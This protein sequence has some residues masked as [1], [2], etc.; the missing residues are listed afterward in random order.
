ML[1]DSVV[2]EDSETYGALIDM[3]PDLM[4][5]KMSSLIPR[6][7]KPPFEPSVPISI[8][9]EKEVKIEVSEEVPVMP[10]DLTKKISG[11]FPAMPIPGDVDLVIVPATSD[12][13]EKVR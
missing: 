10:I 13:S 4:R 11:A 12:A 9:V 7:E 6:L 1:N 2:A 8:E 3:L 5:S